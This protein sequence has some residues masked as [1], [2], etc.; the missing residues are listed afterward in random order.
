MKNQNSS[1]YLS[2]FFILPSENLSE[3]IRRRYEQDCEFCEQKGLDFSS[4][5]DYGYCLIAP[6]CWVYVSNFKGVA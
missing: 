5:E 2:H 6:D 3:A 4:L 1:Y